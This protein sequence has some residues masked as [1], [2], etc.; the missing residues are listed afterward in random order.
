MRLKN[1]SVKIIGIPAAALLDPKPEDFEKAN[2]SIMPDET[3]GITEAFANSESAQRLRKLGYV[4]IGKDAA[5]RPE[6]DFEAEALEDVQPAEETA[7]EEPVAPK[8][9]RQKK[10]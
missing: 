1:V 8:R 5:R 7:S 9:T 2:V 6:D 3:V 4:K 10:G